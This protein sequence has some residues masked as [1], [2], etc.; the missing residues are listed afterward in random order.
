MSYVVNI[1]RLDKKKKKSAKLL[2]LSKKS[3]NR[4]ETSVEMGIMGVLVQNVVGGASSN[5]FFVTPKIEYRENFDG[6]MVLFRGGRGKR[7]GV[8]KGP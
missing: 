2:S 8:F 7:Y 3:E 5:Q 1:K 6:F 4:E